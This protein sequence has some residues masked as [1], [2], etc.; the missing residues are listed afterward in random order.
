[1]VDQI[2]VALGKAHSTIRNSPVVVWFPALFNTAA[3][4]F[5]ML[6]VVLVILPVMPELLTSPD[7]LSF[8]PELLSE[9]S[10]R[11]LLVFGLGIPVMAIANAGAVFMQA[12]AA[13]GEQI[14]T[15]HFLLGVRTIGTRVLIGSLI[16]WGAYALIFII[17]VLVFAQGIA[18]IL[19]EQGMD[20]IPSPEVMAEVLL[21]AMPLLIVGAILLS[22]LSIVFS[23]WAR[24]LAIREVGITQALISG[25]KFALQNFFVIGVL[26]LLTWMLTTFS[27]PLVERLPLGGL[28]FLLLFYVARVYMSL[29][30]MHLYIDKTNI[31]A[32]D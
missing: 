8:S 10:G 29:T 21:R 31:T 3:A 1:M 26:I 7:V 27:Q 32:R 9:A 25:I 14:D 28:W 5:V 23:M 19:L 15:A 12:R 6:I 2:R 11:L 18:K 16:V 24:V 17:S 30:L 22:L 4:V 13:K 20:S